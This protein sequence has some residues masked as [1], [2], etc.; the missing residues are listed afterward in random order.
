MSEWWEER[1][2][3]SESFNEARDAIPGGN[4]AFSSHSDEQLESWREHLVMEREKPT[5]EQDLTI[6]GN[7]ERFVHER[8]VE[9]REK[10]IRTIEAEQTHR[11][12]LQLDRD[13]TQGRDDG[14]ERD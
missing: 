10:L 13:R 7:T 14:H 1:G 4:P 9:E 5:P 2:K 11:L 6:G 3:T 8:V 12:M